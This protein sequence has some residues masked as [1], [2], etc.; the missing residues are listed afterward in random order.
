LLNAT[1]TWG[2]RRDAGE[3]VAVAST[4]RRRSARPSTAPKTPAL[5]QQPAS[6]HGDDQQ[7]IDLIENVRSVRRTLD[8]DLAT[9]AGAVDAERPEVASDILE[10]DRAELADFAASARRVLSAVEPAGRPRRSKLPRSRALL[11]LPA[12]P[13]VGALAMTA[14]AALGGM[15]TGDRH[16]QPARTPAI[17]RPAA[18]AAHV[19]SRVD[20]PSSASGTLQR[21][22]HVVTHHPQAAQVLAVAKDLHN[23]LTAMIATSK[24]DPAQLGVVRRLLQLE[25]RVLEVHNAPGAVAAL[26]ESRQLAALLDRV[27]TLPKP[28]HSSATAATSSS[29][30]SSTTK[31]TTTPATKPSSPPKASTTSTTAKQKHHAGATSSTPRTPHHASSKR[32]NWR[33]TLFGPGFFSN[34]L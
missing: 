7:I 33:D 34:F 28:N 12:V 8:V 25:Q 30:T 26:A 13:L 20:L 14:A 16:D 17:T 6:R 2:D 11:A 10:A 18:P 3:E 5:P 19:A 29:T 23:Q 32:S 31:T 22:E 1:R 24:D 4:G 27:P 9:A 15:H 21:L